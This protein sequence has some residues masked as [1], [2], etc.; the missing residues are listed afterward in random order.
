[1]LGWCNCVFLKT[2]IER[3]S[4]TTCGIK[5][6]LAFHCFHKNTKLRSGR[7]NTFNTHTSVLDMSSGL[8]TTGVSC[9]IMKF[10]YQKS[11]TNYCLVCPTFSASLSF[12]T[13]GN[14]LEGPS[15]KW[16]E[17]NIAASLDCLFTQL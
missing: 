15:W 8:A 14:F 17:H 11:I 7:R 9:K 2:C 6:R 10:R 1:M 3:S 16:R 4:H 5:C 13:A 12:C